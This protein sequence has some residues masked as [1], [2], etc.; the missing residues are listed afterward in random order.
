MS[1][2]KK[3]KIIH[4]KVKKI[5]E[6]VGS[7]AKDWESMRK[8]CS[9]G[10][11]NYA[12]AGCWWTDSTFKPDFDIIPTTANNMFC[13]AKIANFKTAIEERGIKF[14]LSHVTTGGYLFNGCSE[15]L[16]LP[17]ID[18]SGITAGSY[19]IDNTFNSCKKLRKI[20]MFVIRDDGLNTFVSTFYNCTA[21]EEIN[22]TGTIGNDISFAQSTKLNATSFENIILSLS[23]T[24]TGKTVTFS[25]DAKEAAFTDAQWEERI[26][27]KPNWTFNLY[28]AV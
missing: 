22:I 9:G 7:S 16:E 14:D 17:I 15:L 6:S 27:T 5:R 13:A 19:I 2:I 1:I 8:Y 20:D 10:N 4:E 24:A 26:E 21:L 25:R 18:L 23:D 11:Y 12:F 3:S 28:P